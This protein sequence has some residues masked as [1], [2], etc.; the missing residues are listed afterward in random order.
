[1]SKR[2]PAAALT[3]DDVEELAR[4]L[5]RV[6]R[7]TAY[8]SPA[9][10]IDGKLLPCVPMHRSAEPQSLAV[11]IDFAATSRASLKLAR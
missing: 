4:D 7:G 5:P 11:R 9:L 2:P 3:F 8:G 6:E 10:K 1:M